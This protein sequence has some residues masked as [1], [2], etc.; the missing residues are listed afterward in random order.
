MEVR[1]G[2][3]TTITLPENLQQA[4]QAVRL[5]MEPEIRSGGSIVRPTLPRAKG[6]G[7][8]NSQLGIISNWL[9]RIRRTASPLLAGKVLAAVCEKVSG[10]LDMP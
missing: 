1:F 10:V 2:Q 7:R 3:G 5:R 6:S 4:E 9:E 8:M